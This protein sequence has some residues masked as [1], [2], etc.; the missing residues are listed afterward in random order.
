MEPAKVSR[1]LVINKVGAGSKKNPE[2]LN[3]PL[4]PAQNAQNERLARSSMQSQK[5]WI[6][7]AEPH[8]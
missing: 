3:W 8:F 2:K 6:S 1:H 7:L 4:W 5:F